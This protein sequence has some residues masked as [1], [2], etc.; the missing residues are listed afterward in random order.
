VIGVSA[1]GPGRQE[2]F[3]ASLAIP[4][5]MIGDEKGKIGRLYGVL[6]PFIGVERRV[7]FVIDKE[8]VVKSVH[9]HEL[10][11]LRHVDDALAMLKSMQ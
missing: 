2:E 9:N 8:G 5:P 10:D 11:A 4:F 7:T 1:D 3:A 6:W